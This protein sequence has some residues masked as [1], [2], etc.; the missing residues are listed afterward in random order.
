MEL[1]GPDEVFRLLRD[2]SVLIGRNQFRADGRVDD[3]E[4]DG[5]RILVR[6]VVSHPRH[7]VA[8]QRLGH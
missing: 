4:Q 3:V 6:I 7:Q 5:A 8:H 1:V 2:V